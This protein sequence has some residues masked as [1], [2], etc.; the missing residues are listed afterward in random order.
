MLDVP[1]SRH[2]RQRPEA[3]VRP[4]LGDRLEGRRAEDRRVR[5]IGAVLGD[6]GEDVVGDAGCREHAGRRVE[7][8]V[9]PRAGEPP[10]G[11]LDDHLGGRV[12][13][14]PAEH[15][16]RGVV[17][18]FRH[19]HP[20]E[21]DALAARLGGRHEPEGDVA[22]PA[23]EHAL[24]WDHADLRALEARRA[25]NVQ[26]L[27]GTELDTFGGAPG[28]PCARAA[29]GPPPTA[30]GGRAH[31]ADHRLTVALQ[32]HDRPP[33][34][35]ARA[36]VV[37]AVDPVEDP[38]PRSETWDVADLLTDERVLGQLG[39]DEPEHRLLDKLVGDRHRRTVTLGRQA[40]LVRSEVPHRDAVRLVRQPV[41]EEE[42]RREIAHHASLPRHVDRCRHAARPSRPG[43][44]AA[45]P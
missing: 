11:L 12:V 17:P 14:D 27:R 26:A 32:R 7:A 20:V 36:V 33:A 29:L 1:A 39:E 44:R 30:E 31:Q 42:V 25:R 15:D 2:R 16:H 35:A 3:E 45:G 5:N 21:G 19:H 13:P 40:Q 41:R 18:P 24:P 23:F 22:P 8:A 10:A 43:Q 6:D 34:C 4:V 28:R 9:T 38:P 37:G